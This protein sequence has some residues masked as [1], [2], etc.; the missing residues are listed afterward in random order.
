MSDIAFNATSLLFRENVRGSATTSSLSPSLIRDTRN[1]RIDPT[2]GTLFSIGVDGAALGGDNK[3]TKVE[4]RFTYWFPIKLF[5]WESTFAFNVRGGGANP[6]NTIQDFKL[7]D[8]EPTTGTRFVPSPLDPPL[9]GFTETVSVPANVSTDVGQSTSTGQTFPLSVLDS[10]Q[11]LPITERFFLGGLNSVRGYK[12][13]SLGPRRAFLQP[14]IVNGVMGPVNGTTQYEIVDLNGNGTVDREETEVVGGNK[15]A[16][17]N[18]EYQFPLNKKAGVGGLIFFD[19]GQAFAEGD[20]IKIGDLRYAGGAGVRWRSPFGPLRF[21]W[22][23]PLNREPGEDASV[24][25][26]S[27]GSS[28]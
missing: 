12:A 19:G 1:D 28:F 14:V 25:E 8:P 10:D 3:F 24:F 4:A 15:Y 13:R 26:F 23:F 9:E 18:L 7:N 16:L 11:L 27:V 5:P 2:G 21:E 20:P 17:F 22:G 6:R